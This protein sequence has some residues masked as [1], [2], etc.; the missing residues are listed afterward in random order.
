[1]THIINNATG[2]TISSQAQRFIALSSH[3]A[4]GDTCPPKFG[5]PHHLKMALPLQQLCSVLLLLSLLVHCT[6]ATDKVRHWHCW[7][8][9][10]FTVVCRSGK[11]CAAG[12]GVL[13]LPLLVLMLQGL[14]YLDDY[15]FDKVRLD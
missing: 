4:S 8:T 5:T 13:T 3:R 11:F 6:A 2:Q 12:L 15:L 9:C 7:R 14:L 10:E 1:M